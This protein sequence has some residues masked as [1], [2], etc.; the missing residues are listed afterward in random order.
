AARDAYLVVLATAQ[1]RSTGWLARLNLLTA[2]GPAGDRAAV[3]RY[4]QEL[5]DAALPP[6]LG[7]GFWNQLGTA[8]A[9]L[10]DVEAA[11]AA[12]TRAVAVARKH[13]LHGRE[14]EAERQIAQLAESRS[15]SSR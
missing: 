2:V 9:A 5:T 1:E 4:R 12:L 13:K 6:G 3:E 8:Y 7:F 10:G 14:F 15:V 11:E